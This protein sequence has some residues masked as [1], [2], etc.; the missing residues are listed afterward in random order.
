MSKINEIIV[1][2]VFPIVKAVGKV[3]LKDV[4]SGVKLHNT[5]EVY[6]NTLQGLFSD[7][8]LLKEVALK[9]KT[10]IDDGI[11][12]LVLEAVVESA[13]VDGIVLS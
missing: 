13:A 7:F 6:R 3:E 4:L 12:D 9:S 10:K 11:I 5:P 2:T 1:S 8:S